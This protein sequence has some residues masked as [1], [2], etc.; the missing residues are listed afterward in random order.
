MEHAGF[1]SA[2]VICP[3]PHFQGVPEKRVAPPTVPESPAFALRNRV[4]VERKF[5]EVGLAW[6]PLM[7]ALKP[8]PYLGLFV[9]LF[10]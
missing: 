4:R 7:F 10:I 6:F 9:L 1:V 2:S 3:T 5:E 8:H